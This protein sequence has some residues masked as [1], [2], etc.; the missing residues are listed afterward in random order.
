MKR[1]SFLLACAAAVALVLGAYAN[2]LDNSFHFDDA[3]VIANNL[4]LRSLDYVPCYFTDAYTFSSLPANA[5]Y[6]P[7]VTLSLA[8]DYARGALHPRPYHVT[9]IALLLITGAL[10]VLFF[11]PIVGE[12]PALFAATFFCVHTANTETMNLISARSELLSTIGLLAS[13]V[14]YQRSPFARCTLLYLVPLAIGAL[15]KAPLVVFAPLLFAYAV[16]IEKHPPRRALRI[17]LPALILGVGLLVFLNSMNVKEW[18]SGGGPAWRYILTQPF[19][20]L[21]YARLFVLPIGLTADTDMATF[22]HWYDPRAVAGYV[23]VALLIV[24][25]RRAPAAVAFGLTWF[26]I[27]LLP[28]SLFPLA[29]VSNEHRVF[30]AF[31]GLVL[32][33]ATF[34]RTRTL[35][36]AAVG[37]VCVHVF[38]THERNEVWRSEATLWAD[39]VAKSPGN[40]RAWMNYG[41]TQMGKGQFVAAK[42]TFERAAGLVPDYSVLEINRGIVE[43]ELGNQAAAERHFRRAL[44]LNP[45]VNA[46]FFYARWLE[47][48]GRKTEALAHGREAA[49]LSPA[50]ANARALLARLQ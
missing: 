38:A 40:G 8:L 13:F 39:V 31:I 14:L 17:A 46:H 23:F 33:L 28:T 11:M 5:T 21:H 34:V 6:R 4:Y 32:V 2:S 45:D 27:A 12:W 10:L 41:L 37:L 26:A 24:A 1:T 50:S 16:L 36:I 15:A 48:R 42:A 25:I 35:A 3:H 20:W 9:Q 43:G 44:Q 22:A 30:F 18:Q 19:I 29:E 47:K 7:L 49:R